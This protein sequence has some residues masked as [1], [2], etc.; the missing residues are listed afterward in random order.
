[1]S[2][3]KDKEEEKSLTD[4]LNKSLLQSFLKRI[5]MPDSGVPLF[6][7]APNGKTDDAEPAAAPDSVEWDKDSEDKINSRA[8]STHE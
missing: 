5:N 3:E 8:R 7:G 6:E 4:H 1:M 2:D